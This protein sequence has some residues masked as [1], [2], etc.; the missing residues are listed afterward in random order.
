VSWLHEAG[1]KTDIDQVKIL[2]EKIERRCCIHDMKSD[3]CPV[4]HL[5][6]RAGSRPRGSVARKAG[7]LQL[8]VNSE[9]TGLG[10]PLAWA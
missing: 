10:E 9:L 2:M 8:T 5:G 7:S 4:A 3:L 1:E 6:L